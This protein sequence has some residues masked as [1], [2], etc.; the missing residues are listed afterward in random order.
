MQKTILYAV[1]HWGLGH[2]TRSIPII[3][4]LLKQKHRVII[5]SDGLALQL[6][7]K[8]FPSLQFEET[9]AYD[10]V[11]A[12]SAKQFNIKL[13]TQIPKFVQ[14]IDREQADCKRL[15]AENKVDYIISDNRYGFYHETIPSAFI[16][17]QLHLLYPSN[18]IAE[19]IINKNYQSYLKRFTA[20]WVPD[21]APPDN[22]S[23]KMS[24]LKWDK[25]SHLGL[26][27]RFEQIQTTKKYDYLAILSGPEPQRSILEKEIIEQLEQSDGKHFLV[28]GTDRP[29]E[30][31][32]SKKIKVENIM[33]GE[34]INVLI[35]ASKYVVC[36]AGYTSVLDL[37]KLE[38]K[39]ILIPTPGQAEQEYLA[40]SLQ[41]KNWFTIQTQGKI[42]V[43]NV[44]KPFPPKLTFGINEKIIEAFLSCPVS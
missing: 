11:Y 2:A 14:A 17:H 12:S 5:A 1:L 21:I 39:A 42:Q 36:R 23:Q 15:C 40:Q 8:E 29:L 19:K 9:A 31:F 34:D 20:L 43:N 37:L 25:V 16:C 18:F 24:S 27:S 32:V 3:A 44:G 6:L 30:G 38:A 10:V 41:K 7:Q 28:R 22:I 4:Y 26:I 13:A 33:F 35:C